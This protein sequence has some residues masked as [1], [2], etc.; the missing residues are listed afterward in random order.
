MVKEFVRTS[1]KI[2]RER[3]KVIA[4]K[5]ETVNNYCENLHDAMSVFSLRVEIARYVQ[6]LTNALDKFPDIR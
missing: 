3:D 5:Q 6:S 1:V 2:G 4:L